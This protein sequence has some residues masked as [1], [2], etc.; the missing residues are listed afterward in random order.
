MNFESAQHKRI[1][2]VEDNPDDLLLLK[3][4]AHRSSAK[5][6]FQ[7]LNDG[8]AAIDYL[9]KQR[10]ASSLPDLVLL[11]LYLPKKDGLELLRWI[12]RIPDLAAL[13]VFVWTGS[14]NP[15]H[16]R[17]AKELGADLFIPK[18]PDETRLIQLITGISKA[19]PLIEPIPALANASN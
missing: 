10:R 11:D 7:I 8:Q 1:V 9:Q 15:A 17:R 6:D 2:V 16:R 3:V 5:I 19:A 12:R 14:E 13:K 18:S 4:A